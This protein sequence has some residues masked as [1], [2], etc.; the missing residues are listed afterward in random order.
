[1]LPCNLNGFFF[2]RVASIKWIIRHATFCLVLLTCWY[3]VFKEKRLKGHEANPGKP[4]KILGNLA[5]DPDIYGKMVGK[6]A[7]LGS[8]LGWLFMILVWSVTSQLQEPVTSQLQELLLG[9]LT[10]FV[11]KKPML[12]ILSMEL[13]VRQE[14]RMAVIVSKWCQNFWMKHF[15]KIHTMHLLNAIKYY[16]DDTSFGA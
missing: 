5:W 14:A 6:Y 9:L 10:S 15:T 11:E 1:M 13:W 16:H 12:S 8:S 3:L 4:P 2:T 7:L